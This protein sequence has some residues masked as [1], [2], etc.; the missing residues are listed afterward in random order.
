MF[1][2]C[3]NGYLHEHFYNNSVSILS[4]LYMGMQRRQQPWDQSHVSPSCWI[5]DT[6][7]ALLPPPR[8]PAADFLHFSLLFGKQDLRLPISANCQHLACPQSNCA[9]Q[10]PMGTREGLLSTMNRRKDVKHTTACHGAT[11]NL[12][13]RVW[14]SSFGGIFLFPL[15][16]SG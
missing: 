5:L 10:E 9:E 1:I 4:V 16:V 11:V 2:L 13:L 3:Q 8:L 6:T 14:I 15:T 12:E 7:P